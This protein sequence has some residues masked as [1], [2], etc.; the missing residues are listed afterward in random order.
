MLTDRVI[1]TLGNIDRL[2][3]IARQ[4]IE[5]RSSAYVDPAESSQDRQFQS[6][7]SANNQGATS[8]YTSEGLSNVQVAAHHRTP[9]L[10]EAAQEESKNMTMPQFDLAAFGA[11]NKQPFSPER[12][13]TDGQDKLLSEPHLTGD[14]RPRSS[15]EHWN[16]IWQ[17]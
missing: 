8:H 7:S 3:N 14:S 12:T 10:A 11:S 17:Q 9:V 16:Q 6:R 1:N 2:M 13:I 15:S 5:D 4:T